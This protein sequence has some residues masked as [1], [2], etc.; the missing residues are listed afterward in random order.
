MSIKS[1]FSRA[2]EALRKFRVAQG[3]NVA[4]TFAIATIPV[5]GAVGAAVDYSHANSVKAAMQSALG[6]QR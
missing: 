2:R 5:A 3:G 4:I 1:V 6:P